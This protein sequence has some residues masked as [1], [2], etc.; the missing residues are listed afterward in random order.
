MSP[1]P[2]RVDG[3]VCKSLA[4]GTFGVGASG[5][6]RRVWGAD[7][8]GW[9]ECGDEVNRDGAAER[10]GRAREGHWYAQGWAVFGLW[11]VVCDACE[12]RRR[13]GE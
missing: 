13:G 4:A 11:A 10:R 5:R 7:G 3:Q 12:E 6:S 8:Y 9:M 2:R 1:P